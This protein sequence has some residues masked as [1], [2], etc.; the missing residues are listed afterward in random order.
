VS[1]NFL[2]VG[3]NHV[4]LSEGAMMEQATRESDEAN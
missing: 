4:A 3:F 1:N 2:I